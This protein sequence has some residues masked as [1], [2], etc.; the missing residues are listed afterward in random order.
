MVRETNNTIPVEFYRKTLLYNFHML[1][2]DCVKEIDVMD[3]S[4]GTVVLMKVNYEI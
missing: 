4:D 1:Q 3:M 2:L